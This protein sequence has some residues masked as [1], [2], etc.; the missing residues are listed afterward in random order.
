MKP[1]EIIA[2]LKGSNILSSAKK[3]IRGCKAI[4]ICSIK[5]SKLYQTKGSL[6]LQNL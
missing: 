4:D 2:S 5:Q 1:V 6:V 3:L